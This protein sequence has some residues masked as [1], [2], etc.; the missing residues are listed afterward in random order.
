[1]ERGAIILTRAESDRGVSLTCFE[2]LEP[3]PSWAFDHLTPSQTRYFTHS[4]HRYPAKF[5]PQIAQRL[6]ATYSEEGEWVLDPFMGSG[7]TLVEAKLHKR[8]SVGVD[9]NPV[10]YLVSRA[11]VTSIPPDILRE[12]V[13]HLL[14]T[15][16]EDKQL[17]LFASE[18]PEAVFQPEPAAG[19]P[20]HKEPILVC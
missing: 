6:I 18:I 11:K 19:N 17:S 16:Q 5:I 13:H 20:Q 12:K 7:T 15:L 1:M 10:T 2:Q 3:D 8:P 9:I 4:Y 14:A